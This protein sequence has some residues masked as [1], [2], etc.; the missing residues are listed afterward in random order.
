M[1]KYDFYYCLIINY[2]ICCI[3]V[4]KQY[5]KLIDNTN[6]KKYYIKSFLTIKKIVNK[7]F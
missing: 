5:K 2:M 6:N 4:T 7:Y 1:N 3:D